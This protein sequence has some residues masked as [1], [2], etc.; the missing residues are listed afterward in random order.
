MPLCRFFNM[1]VCVCVFFY[2]VM[3]KQR[4]LGVGQRRK[5]FETDTY[6]H[7]HYSAVRLSLSARQLRCYSDVYYCV[8]TWQTCNSKSKITVLLK[9]CM[10]RK[11]DVLHKSGCHSC[12]CCGPFVS[13]KSCTQDQFIKISLWEIFFSLNNWIF[14]HRPEMTF[15]ISRLF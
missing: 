8:I 9:C 13:H 4:S 5:S 1:C 15:E 11:Y 12:C 10:K 2:R 6:L 14:F 7:I 3:R